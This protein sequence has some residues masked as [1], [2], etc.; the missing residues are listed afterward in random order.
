VKEISGDFETHITAWPH[1]R[2]G[3]AAFAAEHGLTFLEIELDRAGRRWRDARRAALRHLL[4][5]IASGPYGSRLVLRGSAALPAWAGDRAREPGDLDFVVTPPGIG[6]TGRQANDLLDGIVAAASGAGLRPADTRRSEIWTYERADGRR[7][8]IPFAG[9]GIPDGFVQI[10]V[11][12]GEQLPIPPEPLTLPGVP[13][14]VPA[15]TAA[16]SLAWKLLWL[17]TDHY[18]QGKDLYDAVLLAEHTTVDLALVRGLLRDE[19]GDEAGTF[20]LAVALDR[21]WRG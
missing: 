18:P 14:P 11:V 1:Q 19:L 5:G 21:G 10:D 7:L 8:V 6:S 16:L 3:L 12:F 13:V 4:T 2:A 15:A 17:A 9:A 20:A